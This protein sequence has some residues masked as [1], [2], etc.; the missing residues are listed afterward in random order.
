M[1]NQKKYTLRELAPKEMPSIYPLLLQ[2]NPDL[3]EATF[4]E[5]LP[6]MLENNYRCLGAF[7][8]SGA[9][10]GVCGFWMFPRIWCGQQMDLDNFVID[11]TLRGGGLGTRMMA[12]LEALAQE[13][14]VDT[15][16]LDSYTNSHNAHKLYMRLGYHIRGYHFIKPLKDGPLTGSAV[17]IIPMPL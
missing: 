2:V 4:G 3:T 1:D 6:K 9:L 16:V 12:W 8:R 17:P 7:N 5:R 13:S 14:D 11:K 15:I 10:V